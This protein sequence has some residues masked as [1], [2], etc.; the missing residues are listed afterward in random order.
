MNQSVNEQMNQKV[1][2]WTNEWIEGWVNGWIDEWASFLCW[3]TS[4]LSDIFAEAPLLSA[5]S[6]LSSHLSGLLLLWAAS[7]LALLQLLQPNSSLRAAGT[8]RLA[9]SSCNPAQH[10]SST[11]AQNY[12]LCSCCNAGNNLQ[13]QSRLPGASQHHSCFAARSR[14]NT[15]CHSQ[16]QTHIE[17]ASQQI[18]QRSRSADSGDLTTQIRGCSESLV[19]I[20]LQKCHAPAARSN[21]LTKTELYN[22]VRFLS[23]SRAATAETDTL[24]WRPQEP[25]PHFPK[26]HRV[27]RPKAFSP[28]NSRVPELLPFSTSRTRELLLPAMLLTYDHMIMMMM[29]MMVKTTWWRDE[30]TDWTIVRNPEVLELNFV[31]KENIVHTVH[32]QMVLCFISFTVVPCAMHFLLFFPVYVVWCLS[33]LWHVVTPFHIS[34]ALY[35]RVIDMII[36]IIIFLIFSQYSIRVRFYHNFMLLHIIFVGFGMTCSHLKIANHFAA[37]YLGLSENWVPPNAV[38]YHH[39]PFSDRPIWRF[40]WL[41]YISNAR[42]IWEHQPQSICLWIPMGPLVEWRPTIWMII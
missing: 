7:Q 38:V 17:G 42:F 40:V 21:F 37:S 26:K 10:K 28:L 1:S 5:T 32:S 25:L 14:A 27:S 4:S 6:S 20:L 8:I 16:L 13:L 9:T 39:F 19:H 34:T 15:C 18:D 36:I 11:I 2:E 41:N 35:Q 33:L 29:M 22:V 23:T 12:L 30:K 24:L 3:A 31:W